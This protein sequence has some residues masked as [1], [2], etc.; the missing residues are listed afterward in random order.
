MGGTKFDKLH[1]IDTETFERSQEAR[2]DFEQVNPLYCN[3]L[4]LI[5][6]LIF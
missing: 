1:Y 6:N 3:S 4:D 5:N 2:S